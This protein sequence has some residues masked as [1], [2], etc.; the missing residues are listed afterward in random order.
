MVHDRCIV[1]VKVEQ[2]VMCVLLNGDIAG[3]VG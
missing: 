2:E 3:Y 1:S